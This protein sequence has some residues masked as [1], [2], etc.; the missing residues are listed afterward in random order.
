M[1]LT[2]IQT[3]SI[4]SFIQPNIGD[5]VPVIISS[6]IDWIKDGVSV[7]IVDGGVYDIMSSVENVYNLKLITAEKDTGSIVSS[8][9][10]F[11]VAPSDTGPITSVNGLT[12]P[13]IQ[14][15]LSLS[16]DGELT[17]TGGDTSIDL[18]ARYIIPPIPPIIEGLRVVKNTDNTN[19]FLETNDFAEGWVTPTLFVEGIWKGAGD[20]SQ[21]ELGDEDNWSNS[22]KIV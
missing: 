2:K 4:S 18:D 3:R 8:K 5:V 7:Y 12:T 22:L 6:D 10:L 14:L 11:P 20:P 9:V 21:T 13:N 16:T 17:I 15:D 19:E 1:A